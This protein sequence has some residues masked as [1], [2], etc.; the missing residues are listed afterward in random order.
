M[1]LTCHLK[2]LNIND[3]LIGQFKVREL[4]FQCVEC[5]VVEGFARVLACVVEPL[6]LEL[7]LVE[8]GVRCEPVGRLGEQCRVQRLDVRV[9]LTWRNVSAYNKLS[10]LA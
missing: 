9:Q 1:L 5:C 7:G 2:Q 3:W 4:E 6:L 8:C 10:R